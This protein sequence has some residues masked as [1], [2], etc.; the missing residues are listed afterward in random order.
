MSVSDNWSRILQKSFSLGFLQVSLYQHIFLNTFRSNE[1]RRNDIRDDSKLCKDR[2]ECRHLQNDR[3]IYIYTSGQTCPKGRSLRV[4][5][6]C[7]LVRHRLVMPLLLRPQL[8]MHW[9]VMH[10][11]AKDSPGWS[12]DVSVMD[13]PCSCRLSAI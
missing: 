11:L 9:L 1:R 6:I 13:L 7:Q 8:V 12:G 3:N 4:L 2:R 5:G 10:A